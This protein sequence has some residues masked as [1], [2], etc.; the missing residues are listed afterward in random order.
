[1]DQQSANKNTFLPAPFIAGLA[2]AAFAVETT[3]SLDVQPVAIGECPG[4]VLSV[5]GPA[6]AAGL[7]PWQLDRSKL[8]HMLLRW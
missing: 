7:S 2:T 6:T 4:P 8:A 3:E 1:M 5:F